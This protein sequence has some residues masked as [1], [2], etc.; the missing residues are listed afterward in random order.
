RILHMRMAPR[1]TWRIRCLLWPW[2]LAL[3]LGWS[4]STPVP[5]RVPVE[6]RS[7]Q[8]EATFDDLWTLLAEREEARVDGVDTSLHELFAPSP[9]SAWQELQA[10]VT[11]KEEPVGLNDMKCVSLRLDGCMFGRLTRHLRQI[12][13][14]GP[15][16]S[17][18]IGEIM[19]LCCRMMMDEF[20]GNVAYTHS[21]EMTILMFPHKMGRPGNSFQWPHN[22]R[23]QKWV[24]IGSSMVTAL[25]NRQLSQLAEA[26]G[27]T[28]PTDIV[29]HF[30][31]RVGLFDSEKEALS[32]LLWRAYDCSVNCVQDACHHQGAPLEVVRSDFA[33]KLLWLKEAKLLPLDPHQAYGS[34]FVK[35][36]GTFK[37]NVSDTNQTVIVKRKVNIHVNDGAEGPRNLLLLP[38]RRQALVPEE[39]DRRLQLRAGSYWRY[40]G[41]SGTVEVQASWHRGHCELTIF[42]G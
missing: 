35:G 37:V 33:K 13:L 19:R 8:L 14:I 6:R 40:V 21:D 26:R 36:E 5:T 22:G 29:A 1:A 11:G 23:I 7:S 9:R 25:F 34:M 31:C 10:L 24:S 2:P 38:R 30:D 3:A 41:P 32:L 39:G 42:F 15:G 17:K 27:I 4:F 12:G 20:K 18:D 28:L 16:Y